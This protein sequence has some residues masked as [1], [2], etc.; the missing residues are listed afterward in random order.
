MSEQPDLFP[1]ARQ[2]SQ[3]LAWL[4]KHGVVTEQTPTGEWRAYVL[5]E[6][7]GVGS[8]EDEAIL[9]LCK[10]RGIGIGRWND[11]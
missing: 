1:S 7:F 2:P 11:A 8:T 9:S 4:R 5:D 6:I 3:R 10:K